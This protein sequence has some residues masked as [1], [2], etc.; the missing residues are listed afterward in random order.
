MKTLTSILIFISGLTILTNHPLMTS[1]II[2]SQTTII[3]LMTAN[4]ANPWYSFILFM[5]TISGMMILFIY[6]TSMTSNKKM[7]INKFMLLWMIMLPMIMIMNKNTMEFKNWMTIMTNENTM[8]LELSMNKFINFPSSMIM[9]FLMIYL[10]MMMTSSIKITF[11]NS[12][13]MRQ[14]NK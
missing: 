5:I 3:S 10:F 8:K 11:K 2:I 7:S 4:I 12:G 9:T 13:P 1:M 14:K 6:M